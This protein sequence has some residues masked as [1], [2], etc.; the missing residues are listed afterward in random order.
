M[1]GKQ[2]NREK[3]LMENKTTEEK[4]QMENKTGE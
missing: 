3:K 4:L 1:H 2:V